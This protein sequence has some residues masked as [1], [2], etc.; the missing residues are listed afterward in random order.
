MLTCSCLKRNG[1]HTSWGWCSSFHWI[2][3]KCL[4]QQNRLSTVWG[5]LS[6]YWGLT[7]FKSRVRRWNLISTDGGQFFFFLL[8]TIIV[9]S[10]YVVSTS[11]NKSAM[12]CWSTRIHIKLLFINWP[13][14]LLKMSNCLWAETEKGSL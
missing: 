7:T 8:S 13:T 3:E 9:H 1:K 4:Y 2:A 12:T 14:A 6:R 5:C 11:V 10:L